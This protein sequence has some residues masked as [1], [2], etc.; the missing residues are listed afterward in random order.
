MQ[1]NSVAALFN[2]NTRCFDQNYQPDNFTSC[3]PDY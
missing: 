1:N 2:E 3:N